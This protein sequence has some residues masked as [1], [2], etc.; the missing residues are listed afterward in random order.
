MF[1]PTQSSFSSPYLIL[2]RIFVAFVAIVLAVNVI[3]FLVT[4]L[5]R[6]RIRR[7]TRKY[8]RVEES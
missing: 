7:L 4:Q 3:A 2:F 1:F 6:I 5:Y 8:S